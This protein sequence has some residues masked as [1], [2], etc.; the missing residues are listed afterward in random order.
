MQKVVGGWGVKTMH[1]TGGADQEN[2]TALVTICADGTA[3]HPTIIFDS[4][5]S[6]EIIMSPKLCR[7]LI[8]IHKQ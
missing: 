8:H 4:M 7:H 1:R 2:V 6:G 5:V 3:L